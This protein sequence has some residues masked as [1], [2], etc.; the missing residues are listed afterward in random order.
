MK[1]RIITLALAAAVTVGIA[2][3]FAQTSES[4]VSLSND[5]LLADCM[6][7]QKSYKRTYKKCATRKA[8]KKIKR[9]AAKPAPTVST[10]P[11]PIETPPAAEAPAPVQQT[12]EQKVE[13]PAVVDSTQPVIIDRFEKRHRSLIHLGLF[14][15]N[16]FGQ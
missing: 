15:F 4:A 9:A 10:T 13:Q 3:A 12:V 5:N 14:P 1:E 16:L 7:Q 11:A 2:P 8:A 6:I